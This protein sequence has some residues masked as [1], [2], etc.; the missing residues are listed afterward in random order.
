MGALA[1]LRDGRQWQWAPGSGEDIWAAK[2]DTVSKL[3]H[4]RSANT[5]V[6]AKNEVLDS[7]ERLVGDHER[8]H[9]D[10]DA[11]DGGNSRG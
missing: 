7:G 5:L 9:I 3:A 8:P 11:S 4:R 10:R 6:V 2:S 1:E